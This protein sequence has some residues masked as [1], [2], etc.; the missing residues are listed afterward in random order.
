M[1]LNQKISYLLANGYVQQEH[2]QLIKTFTSPN[3][4]IRFTIRDLMFRWDS[5]KVF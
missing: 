4:Q 1:T 3:G 5:L 2:T